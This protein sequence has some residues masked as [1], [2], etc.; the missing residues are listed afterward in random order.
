MNLK[1][2]ILGIGL[3]ILSSSAYGHYKNPLGVKIQMP[4]IACIH[5]DLDGDRYSDVFECR[6]YRITQE[7]IILSPV[8]RSGKV[9]GD[10]S[11]DKARDKQELE[12]KEKT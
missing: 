2:M 10:K 8:I 1:T 12:P 11:L 4:N 5:Y 9:T 7:G 3:T 6:R